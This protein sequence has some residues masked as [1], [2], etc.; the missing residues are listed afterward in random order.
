VP[1]LLVESSEQLVI[2]IGKPQIRAEFIP[3]VSLNSD[4]ALLEEQFFSNRMNEA[5]ERS[6]SMAFERGIEILKRE[7]NLYN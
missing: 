7:T 1:E 6:L 3:P 4:D 5:D 2:G